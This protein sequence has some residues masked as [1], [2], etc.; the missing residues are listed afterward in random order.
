ML[1]V[2][3]AT[4]GE[5]STNVAR[6]HRA[7]KPG[8]IGAH[9]RSRMIPDKRSANPPA[10]SSVQGVYPESPEFASRKTVMRALLSDLR[11]AVRSLAKHRTVTAIAIATLAL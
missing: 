7:G 8:K 2:P 3:S 5:K 9:G 10:D 1:S 4:G 11:L 6:D